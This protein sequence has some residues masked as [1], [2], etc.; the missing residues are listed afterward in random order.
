ML[1]YSI[2]H[3]TIYY[4]EDFV[5]DAGVL[6]I[7]GPSPM[8]QD[9]TC[10]SGQTCTLDGLTGEFFGTAGSFMALDTCGKADHTSM[11]VPDDYNVGDKLAHKFPQNG[12]V[13]GVVASGARVTWGGTPVTAAGGIYRLCWC[14]SDPGPGSC[15]G[16]ETCDPYAS[17]AANTTRGIWCSRIDHFQVDTGALYLVGPSA[18]FTGNTV[19][20]SPYHKPRRLGQSRTCIS[21]QACEVESLLGQFLSATDSYSVLDTCGTRSLLPRFPTTGVVAVNAAAADL[22]SQDHA[23]AQAEAA[24]PR[25]DNTMALWGDRITWGTEPVTALGG[26]YRLCWCAGGFVCSLSEHFRVDVGEMHVVGPWGRG[27]AGEMHTVSRTCVSGQPCTFPMNIGH[28]LSSLDAIMLLD[29]CGA[30]SAI[31]PRAAQVGVL[32]G[33]FASQGGKFGWGDQ[34]I[35]A[36]GGLYRLCWCSSQATEA[37]Q[38]MSSFR[39]DIGSL[40]LLGPAP[41]YQDRTCVSGRTCRV[42]GFLGEGLQCSGKEGEDPALCDRIWVLDTCGHPFLEAPMRGEA[43]SLTSLTSELMLDWSAWS[44]S[45]KVLLTVA[46]GQYSLCWC[47][48]GIDACS[49]PDNFRTHFGH[50]TVVGVNPLEQDRTCVS[51]LTCVVDGIV[52]QDLSSGDSYLILETCGASATVP[53]TVGAGLA[54]SVSASGAGVGWGDRGQIDVSSS[55]AGGGTSVSF[56][57]SGQITA[58]GGQY[59]LCWCSNIGQASVS[60]P[61]PGPC[62]TLAAFRVD[63]GQ[64][65]LMG[66]APLQQHRTCVSGQTCRLDGLTGTHLTSGDRML[67]LSTC[68]HNEAQVKS[69]YA[70]RLE[71]AADCGLFEGASCGE[72]VVWEGD[73][74]TARGGEYRLCWCAGARA[75]SLAE[76]FVVDMGRLD[77]IGPAPEAQ[78]RTCV[79]SQP[80]TIDGIE[81]WYLGDGDRAMILDTCGIS[82]EYVSG[83]SLAESSEKKLR[84]V[85]RFDVYTTASRSGARITWGPDPITAKGGQ[86]RL[87]WCSQHFACSLTAQFAVDAGELLLVGPSPLAQ[88][89][90][91][92][93]GQTCVLDSF[94]G[95]SIS[96]LDT[97]LILETCNMRTVV[98]HTGRVSAVS[99]S[100]AGMTW[101]GALSAP[102]GE[103]RLCWCS[104]TDPEG[105]LRAR[106]YRVD[107]GELTM[108]GPAPLTQD[109]TCVSGRTCRLDAFT[110][111][112]LSTDNWIR[113]L[114]TCGQETTNLRLPHFGLLTGTDRSGASATWGAT[115]N[116]AAGGEYRLCWCAGM[117]VDTH[118][119]LEHVCTLNEAFRT[120]MGRLTVAGV[121]LYQ[122]RTCVAG[123]TCVLESMM[124]VALTDDD[125]FA[126]MDTCGDLTAIFRH[127]HFGFVHSR[128]DPTAI[129][130]SWGSVPLT[131]AGGQYRLCWCSGS[132]DKVAVNS[133]AYVNKLETCETQEHFKVDAGAL[134]LVGV[135][136]LMQARTCVSGQTCRVDGVIGQDLVI[137]Y[138]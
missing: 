2:R 58:S 50:F 68:G 87:C 4:Q 88:G 82:E 59:R 103:Y 11:G 23:A 74:I 54:V 136:P 37:C 33:D 114:D 92:A 38:E 7:I 45:T 21:G 13:A 128:A 69:F 95:H 80:C 48:G 81:G 135:G 51:G 99:S 77:L 42:D 105:C 9:R 113:V 84:N 85:A 34:A 52:G 120:D 112:G 110:G 64:L 98:D 118:G 15:T 6:H 39:V 76:H 121:D 55:S 63:A 117:T 56:S 91:C 115:V 129:K 41:L 66:P 78:A 125:R 138:D 79:S 133:I 3:A 123:Q 101:P 90:T 31:V 71:A 24:S 86:Y 124:G 134:T 107:M 83:T 100:G 53:L 111:L 40:T 32:Y 132:E 72:A 130:V 119:Q 65:T 73:R 116:T 25:P 17:D 127:S 67:V 70:Q 22:A 27:V 126:I 94:V 97:L 10:V 57:W 16:G 30:G 131:S 75:C 44:E 93:S 1:L 47:A 36:A 8:D 26:E 19:M 14:F 18:L 137:L 109:R 61:A 12:L 5:V 43:K 89:R 46:G 49:V 62:D 29:S 104:G 96:S 106:D 102:G 122:D 28:G 60:D 35:T 108:L 20:T